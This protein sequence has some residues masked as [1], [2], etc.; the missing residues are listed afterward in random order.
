MRT[1]SV[2]LSS[3]R[4]FCQLFQKIKNKHKNKNKNLSGGWP[5][6]W[7]IFRLLFSILLLLNNARILSFLN[8]F[9]SNFLEQTYLSCY[10]IIIEYSQIILRLINWMITTHFI[11]NCIIQ[12]PLQFHVTLYTLRYFK[13]LL[14]FFFK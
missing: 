3:P 8:S 14:I 11:K 12:K 1:T 10:L 9:I 7:S 6:T 5:Y 13:G 4:C 2:S